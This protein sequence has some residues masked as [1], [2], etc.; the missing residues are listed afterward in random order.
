M[1][2]SSAGAAVAGDRAPSRRATT[3]PPQGAAPTKRVLSQSTVEARRLPPV[4]KR[5]P[6]VCFDRDGNV[7]LVF[8]GST[9]ETSPSEPGSAVCEAP[10]PSETA[11][12]VAAGCSASPPA[13]AD[14]PLFDAP[15]A[16]A[17]PATDTA[18]SAHEPD[19]RTPDAEAGL[20]RGEPL[21]PDATTPPEEHAELQ[22]VAG[23][24][25]VSDRSRQPDADAPPTLNRRDG[26]RTME[27]WDLL[28]SFDQWLSTV[29]APT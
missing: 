2:A 4:A 5:R 3:V 23:A 7:F 12:G 13:A 14:R 6:G 21:A 17:A 1:P 16:L 24:K 29:G 25:E 15:S 22:S 19:Q 20:G 10:Q 28:S 9:K 11:P 8:S 26:E 18:Q 27:N